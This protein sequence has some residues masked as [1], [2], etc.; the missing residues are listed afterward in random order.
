VILALKT[1]ALTGCF[2]QSI[3]ICGRLKQ[4]QRLAFGFLIYVIKS[5]ASDGFAFHCIRKRGTCYSKST[6]T[7]WRSAAAKSV[8]VKAKRTLEYRLLF[9]GRRQCLQQIFIGSIP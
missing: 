2:R 6:T 9:I 1:D 3:D 4:S 5:L 7:M 8:G